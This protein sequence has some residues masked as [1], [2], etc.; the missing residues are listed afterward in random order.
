[1]AQTQMYIIDINPFEIFKWGIDYG[2]LLAEEERSSE[3]WADAFNGCLVSQK[4]CMPAAPCERRQTHS[5]A[6][7]NAK[8]ESVRKFTEFITSLGSTKNSVVK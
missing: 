8:K 3:E 6:W 7:I 1:M 4:Y 5:E 2:L